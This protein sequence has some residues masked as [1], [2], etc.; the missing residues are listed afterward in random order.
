MPDLDG[1]ASLPIFSNAP[2]TWIVAVAVAMGAFALLLGARRIV[3]HLPPLLAS[4]C[5]I[6]R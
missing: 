5:S 4:G 2:T 6:S 3:R 1:L